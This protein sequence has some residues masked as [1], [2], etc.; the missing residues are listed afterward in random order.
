MSR[1]ILTN[2]HGFDDE[3]VLEEGFFEK[4]SKSYILELIYYRGK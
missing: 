4:P 3:Y 1:H 2:K